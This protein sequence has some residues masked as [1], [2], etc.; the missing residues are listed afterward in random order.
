MSWF[1][2]LNPD[3][4]VWYLHMFINNGARPFNKALL[5]RSLGLPW[6]A[7][8]SLQKNRLTRPFFLPEN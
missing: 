8:K 7:P 2:A 1:V 5:A 6:A 3:D 4:P